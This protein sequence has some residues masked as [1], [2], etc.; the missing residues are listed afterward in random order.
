MCVSTALQ[1]H[2]TAA[3]DS[4]SGLFQAGMQ[5][6][7]SLLLQFL[8]CI[9][10]ALQ[11]NTC[12]QDNTIPWNVRSPQTHCKFRKQVT[13]PGFDQAVHRLVQSV[14]MCMIAGDSRLAQASRFQFRCRLM[15]V[16]LRVHHLVHPAGS[17][18]VPVN[19]SP[20]A[21]VL[22]ILHAVLESL[23][24]NVHHRFLHALDA[25]VNGACEQSL[26][27]AARPAPWATN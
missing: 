14:L 4:I 2:C 26:D 25:L 18:A 6:P 16:Q 19:Q 1:A 12:L 8:R 27:A 11:H 10:G 7:L 20:S 13:F 22:V 15:S 23:M 17:Q 24:G 21:D 9:S 3:T 5:C